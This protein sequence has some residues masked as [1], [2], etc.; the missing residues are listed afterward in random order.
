[1]N[2]RS[3]STMID[4]F[5]SPSQAHLN[6]RFR[7][8]VLPTYHGLLG[9]LDKIGIVPESMSDLT[10]KTQNYYHGSIETLNQDPW[11]GGRKLNPGGE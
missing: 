2:A 7:F 3:N 8:L 1:M 9:Y 5:I 4:L 6:T 11:M 10:Q